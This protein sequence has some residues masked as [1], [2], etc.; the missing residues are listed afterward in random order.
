MPV[1]WEADREGKQCGNNS[2]SFPTQG[3]G[4]LTKAYCGCGRG[5]KVA[6]TGRGSRVV[7]QGWKGGTPNTYH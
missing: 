5:E 6:R 1:G 2:V 7:D 4:F 3:W